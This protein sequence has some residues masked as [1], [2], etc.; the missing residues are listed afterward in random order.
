M[1]EYLILGSSGEESRIT[2]D[3]RRADNSSF[4]HACMLR[5]SFHHE[6]VHIAMEKH[7]QKG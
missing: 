5:S 4:K 2:V 6:L 1:S 3:G 7:D